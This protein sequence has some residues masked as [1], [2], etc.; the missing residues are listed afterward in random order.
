MVI[1]ATKPNRANLLGKKSSSPNAVVDR[2]PSTAVKSSEILPSMLKPPSSISISEMN[3]LSLSDSGDNVNI[4]DG[5]TT[6]PT[7]LSDTGTCPFKHGT[8]YARPYPGYVH[9]N[10]KK[11][12]CPLGCRPQMNCDI[13]DHET[14]EETLIR[15]AVEFIELYYHERYDE[16]KDADGFMTKEERIKSV[17]KSIEKTGTYEHTFDELQHGAR[18]AW[19]NAPKCSN[20]KYWQNL[21]LI[22]CR[23]VTSNKG[24]YDCCV[25]HLTKAMSC[26]SSE[27]YI[28][29]FRQAKQGTVDGS[30][31]WNDQ[32]LQY[33]AYMDEDGNV[34]GDPKNLRFTQMLGERFGWKGPKSGEQG[35]YDYLPLVIQADPHVRY[36][37]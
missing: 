32:L 18:V 28:S 35:P 19:R 22:D 29:V 3:G 16:M 7:T 33:A 1:P 13:T 8:V 20:R 10:P 37:R 25:D 15:E 23:G 11:G 36:A 21:K 9:G 27:A 12:V 2:V 4:K 6:A 26:G 14:S 5:A 24:M 30:R 17:L 34:T 31:I